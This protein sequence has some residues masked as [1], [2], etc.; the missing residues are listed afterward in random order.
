LWIQYQFVVMVA[1]GTKVVTYS[2]CLDLQFL[3]Q[4]N[5]FSGDLRI[6]NIQGYDIILGVDWLRQYSPMKINWLDKWVS[7]VKE[8]KMVKL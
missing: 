2:K 4:N 7:V 6:L 5:D 1:E 3:L 8:G